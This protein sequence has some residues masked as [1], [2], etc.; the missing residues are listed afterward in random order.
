VSREHNQAMFDLI[1][2][3]GTVHLKDLR[4]I[5][6]YDEDTFASW[7]AGRRRPPDDAFPPLADAL[8]LKAKELR[9]LAR[10]IRKRYPR[11]Q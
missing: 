1:K 6:G 2:Q 10:E 9:A 8:D 7:S 5:A 3:R 4:E 11:T